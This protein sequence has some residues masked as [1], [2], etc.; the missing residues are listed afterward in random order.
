M[1]KYLPYQDQILR[2]LMYSENGLKF[3]ELQIKNITS[4]HF[5]YYI[6]KLLDDELVEKAGDL[7][8]LN[9]KGKEYIGR[10]DE[11]N[12]KLEKLPKVSVAIF[13]SR[14]KDGNKEFL[15][16]RRLKHPYFGK[17]GG[18]T[19]KVRFGETYEEAAR[20]ELIEET[21]LSGE[22]KFRRIE[23]KFAY[24]KTNRIVQ[25][26]I[27]VIFSVHNTEGELKEKMPEHESFWIEESALMK[28]NDLYNTFKSILEIS[29]T[30]N[31]TAHDIFV[32]AEGF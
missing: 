14:S 30:A 16:N 31:D 28:R 9:S 27:M 12:M 10:V 19:G 11:E 22:F 29:Q 24:D 4:N 26:Q 3:S 21:G 32:E 5:N 18:Y 6:K 15:V 17:V 1:N 25:D 23:R 2:K 7:Y 13:V 20:R 8:K